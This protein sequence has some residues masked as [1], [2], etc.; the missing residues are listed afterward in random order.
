MWENHSGKNVRPEWE[1]FDLERHRDF[2]FL[3]RDFDFFI[4]EH[5]HSI[6]IHEAQRFPALFQELRGAIDRDRRRKNRFLL[7]G[8]SSLE[9]IKNVSESLAGRVGLIEL[10]TFKANETFAVD[11]SGFYQIFNEKLSK[12]TIDYLKGSNKNYLTIK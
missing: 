3:T 1:Y 5:S 11:L 8:S 9:L 4:K 2:D 10:G 12:T 6:V 7:T